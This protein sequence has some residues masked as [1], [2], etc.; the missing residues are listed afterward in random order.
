MRSPEDDARRHRI[1]TLVR[2]DGVQRRR[3]VYDDGTP[4]HIGEGTKCEL[5]SPRPRTGE[6][7]AVVGV[8]RGHEAA[9]RVLPVGSNA[10]D[11][12]GANAVVIVAGGVREGVEEAV[13]VRGHAFH[14]CAQHVCQ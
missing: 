14:S 5:V 3:V 4:R 9:V 10:V 13:A 8:V 12:D 7:G 1:V 6:R 11:D 2:G